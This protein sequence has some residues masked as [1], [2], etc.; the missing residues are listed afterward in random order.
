[1]RI[2][3]GIPE[4]YATGGPSLPGI[5]RV[6]FCMPR[7]LHHP[8]EGYALFGNGWHVAVSTGSVIILLLVV[9]MASASTVRHYSQMPQASHLAFLQSSSTWHMYSRGLST[10]LRRSLTINDPP[11][12]PL[13][14]PAASVKPLPQ[15]SP[16]VHPL[17][18]TPRSADPSGAFHHAVAGGQDDWLTCM[19]ALS[20]MVGGLCMYL[21]RTSERRIGLQTL[22]LMQSTR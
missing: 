12:G 1:M 17:R 7:T 19:G 21:M 9:T 18:S 20:A 13:Q 15:G 2:C 22:E 14:Q 10:G 6:Y 16:V 8:G 4:K 5:N 11:V 3:P